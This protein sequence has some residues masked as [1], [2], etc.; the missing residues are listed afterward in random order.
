[1]TFIES[2]INVALWCL[3]VGFYDKQVT[4]LKREVIDYDTFKRLRRL[5]RIRYIVIWSLLIVLIAFIR[6]YVMV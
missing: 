6:T 4:D 3:C 2:L 1:M 5:L